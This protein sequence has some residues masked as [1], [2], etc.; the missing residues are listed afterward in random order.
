MPELSK[1]DYSFTLNTSTTDL[2]ITEEIGAMI[3]SSLV[4]INSSNK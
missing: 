3:L 4:F 2:N 1:K